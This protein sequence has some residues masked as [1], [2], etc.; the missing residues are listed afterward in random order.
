MTPMYRCI[1]IPP[2]TAATPWRTPFSCPV[3]VAPPLP[4]PHPP[5]A[6]KRLLRRIPQHMV[7]LYQRCVSADATALNLTQK[8]QPEITYFPE[9]LEGALLLSYASAATSSSAKRGLITSSSSGSGSGG[10]GETGNEEGSYG[11]GGEGGVVWSLEASVSNPTM[12]NWTIF[13]ST[14]LLLPGQK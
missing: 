1:R 5:A 2:S 4:P 12:M 7:R 9:L 8:A 10:D 3:V 14:G 11:G 13:P 6:S